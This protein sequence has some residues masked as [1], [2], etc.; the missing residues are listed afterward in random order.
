M[1]LKF[2]VT[3]IEGTSQEIKDLLSGSDGLTLVSV[4]KLRKEFM[5]DNEGRDDHNEPASVT[6]KSPEAPE[7]KAEPKV[8]DKKPTELAPSN[9]EEPKAEPKAK[10]ITLEYLRE[11]MD[12]VRDKFEYG[13]PAEG[14][15]KGP[16]EQMD[17]K[18]HKELTKLFKGFA[19]DLGADKPSALPEESRQ[20][21]IDKLQGL[22]MNG[23]GSITPFK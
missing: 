1:V 8:E 7:T 16:N 15:S 20:A 2:H 14:E 12:K 23:D 17:E 4:E 13:V 19:K 9:T 6:E 3:E 22:Q 11:A 18:I 5:T 21:F 10:S